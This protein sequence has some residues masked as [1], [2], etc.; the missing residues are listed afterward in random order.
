[1]RHLISIFLLFLPFAPTFARDWPQWRGPNRNGVTTEK[2][3]ASRSSGEPRIAWR[4]S[5]G[6]GFSSIVVSH[7]RA[8]TAGHA[9]E[10]DAVF[11]FDAVTGK[12][13]WQQSYPAELGDKYFE[14]G[15]TGTPSFDEG[16]GQRIYWLGRWGD[17]FCL[18]SGTGKVVW[19]KN[20]AKEAGVRIPSWGFTGAPLVHANLLVLNVGEAGMALDKTNG[21]IIWQ[22]ANKDAGYSTPLPVQRDG[23]WLAILGSEKNYLAVDIETG[24]EAWRYRWLT[25]FGVNAADPVVD[26]DR[27]FI[28]TGYGKGA[29][30]LKLGAREPEEIWKSKVLRTQ[31]NAAV[32]FDGHLYGADGDTTQSAAL[33]C[34]DFATGTERWAHEGFGSGGV[35]VAGDDLIACSA[36]GELLIAPASSTA[37]KPF[38]RAQVLGAK[39][40]TAPVLANGFIYCRNARGEIAAIDLREK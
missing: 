29:V 16:D 31:L 36:S 6:L 18:E 1:V 26:G 15:T 33:K 39:C 38:V 11:C 37:F 4:A 24:K 8:C 19:S 12:A 14:G 28:S 32:L 22:S 5:V 20:L 40:W 17:L 10:K 21:A 2:V 7:G 25:Q 13:L 3:P 9:E 23:R 27:V 35:I 34:V 30:L